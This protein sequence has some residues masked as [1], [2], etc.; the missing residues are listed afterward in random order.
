MTN[1]TRSGSLNEGG[2]SDM[3]THENAPPP[4]GWQVDPKRFCPFDCTICETPGHA[5]FIHGTEGPII[6]GAE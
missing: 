5:L 6:R 4:E 3:V 1:L 2:T